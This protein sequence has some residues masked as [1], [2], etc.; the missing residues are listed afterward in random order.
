MGAQKRF[1]L[2]WSGHWR[3]K[4]RNGSLQYLGFDK[5]TEQIP[6]FDLDHQNRSESHSFAPQNVGPK[7]EVLAGFRHRT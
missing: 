2:E 6:D 7:T 4:V 1:R 3:R 5:K